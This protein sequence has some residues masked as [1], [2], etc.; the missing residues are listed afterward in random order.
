MKKAVIY[1]RFSCSKQREA[2]IEDQLRVCREWCASRG[3]TVVHEYCDHA[4]SG[5]TDDRPQFQE[6]I[7][8]AGE[9]EI[10]LVYMMDRFSR[11]IYDAPIYKKKLRDKGVKVVSATESMPDGPE[12]ML[13][14]SIYEAMA[15]ME[16]VHTSQRV[17]RGMQGNAQKCMHN[18]VTLYGYAFGEDGK[19][20]I[21]PE[22]AEVVRECFAR[23]ASGEPVNSI[24]NDLRRRG[25][26]PFGRGL[27]SYGFV[28]NM[29]KNEKYM[30]VYVWGDVRI[31]G[32]MPAI[33]SREEFVM[34]RE[35]KV[36]KDRANEEWR[37]FPL[38]GRAICERC[39]MSLV[40]TSGYGRHG[41]RYDYYK[42]SKRCG[43][44]PVRADWLH[45]SIVLALRE[46]LSDRDEALKVARIV[47][48]GMQDVEIERK[49]LAAAEKRK[50]DAESGIS[51]M[52]DAIAQGLNYALVKG[53]ID[54]LQ[55]QMEVAEN[56]I[57]M[58]KRTKTF[59]VE[60]F[61]DFLQYGSTLDDMTLIKGM[62]YQVMVGDED[63]IVTLNYD[64]KE[65]E[66]ARFTLS[67]VRTDFSWW[68]KVKV[69]RTTSFEVAASG[70]LIYLRFSRAA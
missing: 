22:Q 61:A 64:A 36:K 14:E 17:T 67:R 44:K 33:V 4:M 34:A 51:K 48:D 56:E 15:A 2:S 3:Y 66:P 32:G 19:Y 5:R 6:M 29:L 23:K 9:S 60:K 37:E 58:L 24:A 50:R 20:V 42:C 47:A 30:G 52:A 39:G 10:V 25:I 55:A 27:A 28:Y 63:V 21:D 31:E 65:N 18:G 40:G 53:K 11:D 68:T 8:N 49:K 59:S 35:A 43:C 54:E 7:H 57:R 41:K 26:K 38:T 13:M 12:A 16:S 46:L 70:G 62:V 45:G 69:S 1:A